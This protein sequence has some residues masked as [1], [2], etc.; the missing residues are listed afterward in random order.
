MK[1]TTLK[2]RARP[3][4]PAPGAVPFIMDEFHQLAGP[5]VR[6][7][8]HAS[9]KFGTAKYLMTQAVGRDR[10]GKQFLIGRTR[11]A[12]TGQPYPPLAMKFLPAQVL[13]RQAQ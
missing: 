5:I 1:V 9:R 11:D 4:K 3:T 10:R 13:R 6:S 2:K 12:L 8:N 7:M